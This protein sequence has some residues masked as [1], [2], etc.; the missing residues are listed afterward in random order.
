VVIDMPVASDYGWD[1]PL[2]VDEHGLGIC[3]PISDTSGVLCGGTPGS[4]KSAWLQL[5]L[6]SFSGRVDLQVCIIDGRGGHDHDAL[7]SR[8]WNYIAADG[9]HDLQS[10][11]SAVQSVQTLMRERIA[12]SVGL[13]GTHNLWTA[14]PSKENPAVFLVIDE[15]QAYMPSQFTSKSDKDVASEIVIAI[16]D[17]VKRGRSA[18]VVVFLA[19]QRPTTDSIPSALRDNCGRRVCFSVMNRDS[20]EAVLGA[21]SAEAAVSP[22]RMPPG[23]GV[24]AVGGRLMR[25]RAPF[26]S[27]HAVAQYVSSFSTLA[28]DPLDLLSEQLINISGN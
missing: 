2:G 6:S 9:G 27:E 5:A 24:T 13:Y 7:A 17:L 12:R 25:F 11:L 3:L 15:F 22:I 14:G 23:V 28:A 1:L 8:C 16:T 26:V 4:G 20:A 19:T 21:Y 18:G 10:V